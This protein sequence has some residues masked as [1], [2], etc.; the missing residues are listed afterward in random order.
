MNTKTSNTG[1]KVIK[2][3]RD[4]PNGTK[5]RIFAEPSRELTHEQITDVAVYEKVCPAWSSHTQGLDKDIILYPNDLVS[6]V[7]WPKGV[8]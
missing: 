6:V 5:F 3:F 1:G 4:V 8:K 7:M 2:K